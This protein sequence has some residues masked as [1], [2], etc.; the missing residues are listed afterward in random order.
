[1]TTQARGKLTRVR[2][3]TRGG[4]ELTDGEE[5]EGPVVVLVDDGR[6]SPEEVDGPRPVHHLGRLDGRGQGQSS[7]ISGTILII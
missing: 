6:A 5:R 4:R 7:Y 1:V 2:S 3:R